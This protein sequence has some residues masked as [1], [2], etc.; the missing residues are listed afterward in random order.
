MSVMNT[1]P[2][3]W[4]V[5]SNLLDGEKLPEP[6]HDAIYALCEGRAEVLLM[7]EMSARDV[8]GYTVKDDD[9]LESGMAHPWV[10]WPMVVVEYLPSEPHSIHTKKVGI[11]HTKASLNGDFTA[12]QLEAIAWWMRNKATK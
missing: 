7:S 4:E 10:T 1:S 6:M 2:G 8:L 11:D 5:V 12:D 3:M 9:R